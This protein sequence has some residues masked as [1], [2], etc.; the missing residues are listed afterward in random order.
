MKEYKFKIKD[1]F[2]N[3]IYCGIQDA[4]NESNAVAQIIDF[5]CCANDTDESALEIVEI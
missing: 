4:E 5:Y 1:S 3:R 2:D